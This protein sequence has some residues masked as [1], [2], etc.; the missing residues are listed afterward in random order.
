ME[1]QTTIKLKIPR[2]DLTTA[3]LFQPNTQAA[4]SWVESL[5]VTDT[6][7]V[8]QML[9]QGLNDLNRIKTSPKIRYDIMEILRPNLE[10]AL[11]NL[12]R[13]YLNQPL[14]LPEEP[15][16]MAEFSD[17]LYTLAST[18]YT[19]VAI[20]AIQQRD[21][22]REVN[23]ARLTCQ[24]IQRALLFAGRKVLQTLQLHQSM[25]N[26][27]WQTLHQLYALGEHQRLANLPVPEPLN[28]GSTITAT[29]LQ[30]IMLG[31]CK[32]N[33][34]RQSDMAAVYRGLQQWSELVHLDSVDSQE[35]LFVTDLDSDQPPMYSSMYKA[36]LE[37]QCRF[38]DT[39]SLVAHLTTLKEETG[40]ATINFD[41]NTS[42]P[43]NI[44]DQL[45]AAL[46]S[47]SLR[48]FKRS[49]ANSPLQICVG[50]SSTH[51]HVAG[52]QMFEQFLY[53]DEHHN[54]DG[55][56]KSDNPF[57][58]SH[59]KADAWQMNHPGQDY[60]SDT[61][62]DPFREID[63]DEAS[64]DRLLEKEDRELPFNERYP[65]FKIQLADASSGGYCL[66]W[67]DDLPGDIKAGDIVGLKEEE[68]KDWVIAVIR[69][70]SR[71]DN[72]KT[73]IGLELLSPRAIP[74][75]A[76]IH[77][78]PGEK[79]P[80]SRVLLLPEIALVGQ[81]QTLITPNAGFKERQKV[82]IGNSIEVH[83]VQLLRQIAS[84]GSFA[85]FEFRY[86][87]ELGDVLAE[88]HNKPGGGDFDSLWSNI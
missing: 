42:L 69:W 55:G 86:I 75:G 43:G 20:E 66:E 1:D 15:R 57:L 74:Y 53:G 26:H 27:G 73:L 10:V 65:I 80:P 37:A 4:R 19:I 81:P 72:A 82:T 24:A 2:Q 68:N 48:N 12:S 50:L 45:I 56:E 34:L 47:I 6:N 76:R 85:Q 88:N 59:V 61:E 62:V 46:G 39:T 84:T 21:S 23:P 71:L 87:Q 38:I 30:A 11:V 36:Q 31:C 77:V 9:S 33:H 44:L 79:S 58:R 60:E 25:E 35:A 40:G 13:R 83:S 32:P 54:L 67:R 41:K 64:L 78:K 52:E 22:I 14:I 29:Y 28:G 51:F 16:K 70:L 3:S 17:R 7:S 49:A 5:P 18:A 63:I 8:V